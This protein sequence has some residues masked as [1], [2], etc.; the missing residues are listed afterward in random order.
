MFRRAIPLLS[1]LLLLTAQVDAAPVPPQPKL[2]DTV[3][4]SAIKLLQQRKVQ[5]EIKMSAEQR[6]AIFDGMADIEEDYEKKITELSKMPN[7]PEEAFDKLD[8]DRQKAV[9]KLLTDAATKGLNATQRTRLRQLDWRLRGPIV[10]NDEQIAKK[11]QLTDAQKK[12]AADIAERMKGEVDRYFDAL[13]MGND[14]DK[15]KKDLFASRKDRL[16]E[17]VDALTADQKTAWTGMLGE[18]VVGFALDDLWLKVEEEM[19][20]V[21]PPIIGK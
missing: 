12:K 18:D 7:A 2:D 21:L 20:L 15:A 14:I 5:K 6:V 13:G 1:G 10:F 19:D 3:S 8:K 9:E 11:L 16:K 17:M 4:A